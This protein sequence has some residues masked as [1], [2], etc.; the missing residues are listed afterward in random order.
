MLSLIWKSLELM[1]KLLELV[2][3]G[4]KGRSSPLQAVMI[5]QGI[6]FLNFILT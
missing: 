6:D 2:M 1:T 4:S 5:S 3:S